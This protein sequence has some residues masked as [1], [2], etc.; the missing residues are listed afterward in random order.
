[1]I[2]TQPTYIYLFCF[3]VLTM[4]QKITLL[5]LI[6]VL[7]VFAGCTP[8]V[9]LDNASFDGLRAEIE[10]VEQVEVVAN[11]VNA[12]EGSYSTLTGRTWGR[13]TFEYVNEEKYNLYNLSICT[14]ENWHEIVKK[15]ECYLLDFESI[16]QN[17]ERNKYSMQLSGCYTGPLEI[18][19]CELN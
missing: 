5:S 8:M 16:E 18:V 2:L 9:D 3:I 15:G 7:L 10:P 12:Q 17:L 19:E 4:K 1:M 11:L 6:S 14:D 13:L